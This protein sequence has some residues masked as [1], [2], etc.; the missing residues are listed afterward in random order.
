MSFQQGRPMPAESASLTVREQFDRACAELRQRLRGGEDCHAEDYLSA[1]PS[2][3]E[4][5]D[6]AV[7][8]I[9][10]EFIIRRQLGQTPGPDE[11]LTRFPRWRER[12]SA[13]FADEDVFTVTTE[14]APTERSL[15]TRPPAV[16]APGPG[17]VFA[18]YELL[19]RLGE[20]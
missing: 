2:L 12:L 13:L 14:V 9:F 18:S 19:D 11:W 1:H 6:H 7:G 5:D 17:T 3:A 16:T 8:L 4:S 10:T 15:D 20:G